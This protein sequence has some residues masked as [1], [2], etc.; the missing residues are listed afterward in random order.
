MFLMFHDLTAMI[1]MLSRAAGPRIPSWL[2]CTRSAASVD[3][4]GPPGVAMLSSMSVGSAPALRGS[5]AFRG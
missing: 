2:G 3:L 1:Q 4:S 5:I